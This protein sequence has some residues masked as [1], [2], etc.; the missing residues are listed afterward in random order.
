MLVA[1]LA[2]GVWNA[3]ERYS[4]SEVAVAYLES[5]KERL[6]D[7]EVRLSRS[8][9]ALSTQEGVEREIRSMYGMVRPGEELIIVV[10]DRSSSSGEEVVKKEGWWDRFLGLF[11]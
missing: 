4:R 9:D 3:Y 11:R 6:I 5:E 1:L 8:I 2:H 10:A 7:R